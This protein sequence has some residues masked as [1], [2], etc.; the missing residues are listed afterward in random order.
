MNCFRRRC[1]VFAAFP[2]GTGATAGQC[3]P[4]YCQNNGVRLLIHPVHYQEEIFAYGA[5]TS[6]VQPHPAF[7]CGLKMYVLL[8]IYG[9]HAVAQLVEAL[10]YKPEGRGFDSRWCHW[11]FSLT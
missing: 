7:P 2:N 4:C 10:R 3:R 11:N 1:G 6:S 8:L 9:G 5:A